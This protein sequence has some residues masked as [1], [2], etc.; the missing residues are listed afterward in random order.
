VSTFL[1]RNLEVFLDTNNKCNLRCVTCAF[2]DPRV[3]GL[4]M[5]TMPQEMFSRICTDILPR[6]SYATL[7]CL[8]EPLMTRNFARYLEEAGRCGVPQLE[9]VS[10]GLLMRDEHLEACVAS[11]LWRLT[12]SVD[13]VDATTYEAIRRGARFARLEDSIQRIGQVFATASHRPKLRIIMT[14][15]RE[16]FMSVA[17]AV[18]QFIDWGASEIELRETVTFPNIGLADRQLGDHRTALRRELNSAVA[19]AEDAG[20]PIEVV[21]ENAPELGLNLS[22]IPSCHALERRVAIAANGDVMPCMLWAREPLGNLHLNSFDE[23]WN[24]SRRMALRDEF[25]RTRPAMWC[26]TCTACKDDPND[27]DAFFRLLG[28]TT[29]V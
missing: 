1:E 27:D 28:K 2:S 17:T 3:A 19:I 16:N 13:G 24:G 23:I 11:R 22:S 9:F 26:H 8:T 4:K 7:S 21:S 18:R 5:N 29:P 14:L 12:I 6:A 20:V 10:N 15:I 25:R